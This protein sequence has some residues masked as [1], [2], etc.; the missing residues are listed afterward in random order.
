MSAQIPL[1]APS[2]YMQFL[3][4]LMREGE[5][6]GQANLLGRFLKIFEKILSGI[7]DDARL[8]VTTPDGTLQEREVIGIEHILDKLHDYFDPLFTPPLFEDQQ[9]SADFI[10][11]LSQWVAL[12]QNQT[13]DVKSQ[14][15]LLKKIVPLYKKRGTE[16]GLSE[17]LDIYLQEFIGAEVTIKEFLARHQSWGERHRWSRHGGGR[18]TTVFLFC[19]DSC[20][21][22]PGG[23]S[24][25]QSGGQ[26]PCHRRFRKAGPYVLRRVV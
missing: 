20:G 18:C 5:R 7:D 4:A 15:R 14:R 24:S 3:P 22:A 25:Q 9:S 12:I 1:D 26:H 16:P 23:S 2:S 19:A 6:D 21:S 11:Y 8:L 10:S 17:Y 13:W